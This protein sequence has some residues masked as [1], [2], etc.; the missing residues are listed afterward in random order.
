MTLL[1]LLKS[2]L[3]DFDAFAKLV[4]LWLVDP[5][6]IDAQDIVTRYALTTE[7][8]DTLNEIKD[9]Y[10]AKTSAVQK[11]T[12]ALK[13]KYTIELIASR[14][15]HFGGLTYNVSTSDIKQILELP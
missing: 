8:I 3:S 11:L 9:I 12:Y 10:G 6:N 15:R 14:S 4:F 5:S 2:D 1:D 13:V 7:H